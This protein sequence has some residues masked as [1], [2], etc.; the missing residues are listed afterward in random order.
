MLTK[1]QILKIK[2]SV[3][4]RGLRSFSIEDELIDFVG[5]E[6]A[7]RMGDGQSF[8][9]AMNEVLDKIE[10][11]EI[12]KIQKLNTV[13]GKPNNIEMFQNY[14]KI[15][16]RNLVKHKANTLINVFGLV[17][18]LT[19]S[20]IIGLSLKY[21]F[22]FDDMHDDL[23]QLYRINSISH[24]GQSAR[25]M[26][27]TSPLLSPAI[28]SEIPDVI[29][30]S[31]FRTLFRNKPL[32][33]GDKTFFDYRMSGVHKDFLEMFDFPI[34]KGSS[35]NFDT[36]P[37]NVL[38]SESMAERIFGDEN[39]MQELFTVS[40]TDDKE[41]TFKVI[42]VFKDLSSNS[43]L[44]KSYL[45]FDILTSMES[46]ESLAGKAN[47][48]ST[49]GPTYVKIKPGVEEEVINEK[50]SVLLKKHAGEEIWYEHYVQPVR[51][52]HLNQRG[53]EISAD[54]DI[55]Q[56]YVFSII[57]VLILVIACINYVNLTTAQASIR[58][59]E[60]GVRKVIGAK[61]Q[62]FIAQFLVESLLINLMS[63]LLAVTLV[64]L[65]IPVLNNSFSFNIHFSLQNDLVSIGGL[66]GIVFIISLICGTYPGY[67]L[68]RHN[69]SYLLKSSVS[70]KS[71]GGFFR[72]VLVV[73][74]YATSI[75]LIITTLVIVNQLQFMDK[76]DLGF[77]QEEVVY[78]NIGS[79]QSSKY[80]ETLLA[81]MERNPGVIAASLTGNTLGD[82][83]MSGNG[84][85]VKDMAKAEREMHKILAV[86]YG[87]KN[88]VGLEIEEGRWFSEEYGTDRTEGYVVNEAFIKHFDM[89]NPIGEPLSKNGHKGSIIAVVKDFHF[90]SMRHSIEPLVM[91]MAPRDEFGYWNL[92]VRLNPINSAKTFDDLK[93]IW[94]SVVPDYP[95]KYE[96]LDEKIESYYESD[97][98]FASMF[99]T[100][101]ILAIVVSC[102]GL[103]GLV[104]FTTQRRS[105]EIGVRKVLGAS[106]KRIL[107]LISRDFIKLILIGTVVAIPAAYLFAKEWLQGFEYRVDISIW[108][109][110]IAFMITAFISWISVS[111]ISL[112]AAKANPVD[113]LRA[114]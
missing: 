84:I 67:Y 97:K 31:G 62:Q 3:K 112:K 110:I 5:C 65:L 98:E 61:R 50:L 101:A 58:L 89:E 1:D 70:A 96:F 59:K 68:S 37:N 82:G 53:F 44:S 80:G 51:D 85:L 6:I 28:E 99:S 75:G 36:S 107:G 12:T 77:D 14:L 95:F 13:F 24:M 106:V 87:F 69:A 7:E 4:R 52:I 111:Y 64:F 30:A 29:A 11:R 41:I 100:F 21:E 76:Q 72:K 16:R 108:I 78:V 35:E 93:N 32:K 81:E 74:Q 42:G 39:P 2:R 34:V 105:K 55:K 46:L 113:S 79:A 22:S 43:H 114:E 63:M 45:K 15:A 83:S 27:S 18:A 9:K 66:F 92:A 90:K 38:L 103:I 91:F 73:M 8:E 94:E 54:G 20:I 88:A 49:M 60:V 10:S 56:L 57:G 23:D 71:G 25:H 47:W 19:T 109:F 86:D 40:Q 17:L 26:T 104:A 102:L 33:R 48:N